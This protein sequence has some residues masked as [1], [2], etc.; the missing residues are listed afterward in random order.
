VTDV[1]QKRIIVIGGGLAGTSAAHSLV[2]CGHEVTI[3]EK[4]DRL[5]GRI[6]S[7]LVDG[8]A[9]EMGA[10]FISNAYTN[11][12]GF[13]E[14]N[15]LNQ[16]LYRQN[17]S[18]G[19]FR[20]GK[21]HMAT[22]GTLLGNDTLSWGAK[23]HALP[24]LMRLLANWSHL[25]PHAFYRADKYDN[26]PVVDM[27]TGRGGKEFLEYVLQPILNGYF[28]WTPEHTSE[29]M[30][31]ILCKAAMSHGTYKMRGGLQRIPEKAA[32]GSTV[33]LGHT[34]KEVR[35]D[36]NGLYTVTVEQGHKRRTLQAHGI[37]CATTASVVSKILPDLNEHQRTFFEAVDYSSTALIA[38]TYK[39][40]QTIGDKGIAFPRQEGINLAAIT[41]SP[42]PGAGK[43]A[44]ATLKTYASGAIGKKLC[45]ESDDAITQTLTKTMEPARE[46]V[47]VDNP[48]PVAVHVQQWPEALPMF[49]VGHFKRLRAYE[50]GEIEDSG[51]AIVFAGDYIGGP[52]MEGA[53]TSGLQAAAR[54]DSQLSAK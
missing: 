43:A 26:R 21:V 2:E 20:N 27:L 30:M 35:L 32:E 1:P 47:L 24:L 19:I 52:F 8:A 23:L 11:V 12:R 10:G 42:E 5:G 51:Q 34:V 53:F 49:D 14:S 39:Q 18:S 36:K 45:G 44:L 3:I 38:R 37:V 25:D 16:Q 46:M 17:G 13:L 7:H 6:H 50:N 54:L 48:K 33:L 29:A 22:L 4:N 40:E 41:L 31:L 15:G 9:V 28:Y